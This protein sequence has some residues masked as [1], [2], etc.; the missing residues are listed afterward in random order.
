[1][2]LGARL[3]RKAAVLL[4]AAAI[5]GCLPVR[6]EA[7]RDLLLITIDTLRA[8]YLGCNGAKSVRTPH[9]DR[10]AHE[11]VNFTRA[12]SPVPLTL[13]AHASI[14]TGN[15]PPTHSVRSNGEYV[16]PEEQLSLAE[17]LVEQG[18]QT[19]AFV[20]SFVLDRRFGVG[21]GFHHYDDRVWSDIDE[22]EKSEAERAADEVFAVFSDWLAA[23]DD[24]S[25]RFTWIHL[26]DP[27]APYEPPEP[28]RSEY[29]D[30]PY[31]GEVA[32]VDH[33]VGRVLDALERSGELAQTLVAVVGDHGEGL[34]EHGERTHSLL[35]Y[36]S[37]LH[38]PMILWGPG[39]VPQGKRVDHLV[40]VID[41]APTLLDLL[42]FEAE[43]GEGVSLRPLFGHGAPPAGTGDL[44][45]YSE[46]LYPELA[47]GWSPLYA[48]E[49]AE[50]RLILAP[51]SELFS[52]SRD[53][54]E[55]ENRATVDTGTYQRLQRELLEML[56]ASDRPAQGD[57]DSV[58]DLDSETR[59]RLESLGYL[60]AS[61]KRGDRS[62]P[63]VD[64][65]E[66]TDVWN[67]IQWGIAQMGRGEHREAA[68]T[69]EKVLTI[70]PDIP[71]VYEY[72]GTAWKKSGEE[73]KA[74]E[75][76]RAGLARGVESARLHHELGRILATRGEQEAAEQEFQLALDLD[77][78]SVVIHY[79]LGN[80]Y[81]GWGEHDRAIEHYDRALELNPSYLWAWNGLAMARAAQNRMPE[82]TEA[83]RR[84]VEI[85]PDG[86][87]GVFN[88][89][90]Q[91]ER[92]GLVEEAAQTYRKFLDL[93]ASGGMEA[94]RQFARQALSRLSE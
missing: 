58:G 68:R 45:A 43:L 49:D 87:P 76:Y 30:D 36:N 90:H 34:G 14:L 40:R 86:A 22:I 32:F 15:Y 79:D 16:L 46:S 50:H 38:V 67:Q 26:Y 64:P 52:M 20:A 21:Q 27:H 17:V 74:G 51:T 25:P 93:T 11:G 4:F 63:L 69:F 9:L 24:A 66:N 7:P 12:R 41:L 55:T 42:G 10:L 37:T 80:L 82:A 71:L 81:R 88:L 33:V 75:V 54:R 78:R 19:S 29:R 92:S 89:A 23:A 1:M 18:F 84:V 91:L 56:E 31:A 48:L 2:K 59:A 44:T 6:A 35:I 73:G 8:D 62:G 65:K 47:L 83:F 60:A 72:L 5:V 53:P 13:P 57:S 28:F 3:H 85:A 94:Q 77:P 61:P 70:D 39:V